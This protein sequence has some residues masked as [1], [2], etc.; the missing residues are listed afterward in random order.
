MVLPSQGVQDRFVFVSGVV[1]TFF[2]GGQFSH[3]AQA[4]PPVEKLSPTQAVQP[5]PLKLPSLPQV[6]VPLPS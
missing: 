5:L 4:A 1:V 2:P 6:R 3:E